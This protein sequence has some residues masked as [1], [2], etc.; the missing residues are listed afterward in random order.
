MRETETAGVARRI[1]ARTRVEN[2]LIHAGNL[3]RHGK[4]SRLGGSGWVVRRLGVDGLHGNAE[5][6]QRNAQE[7]QG[8]GPYAHHPRKKRLAEASNRHGLEDFRCGKLMN[9][10]A[11]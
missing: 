8:C 6:R 4:V 10:V 11:D 1:A 5:N 3:H 7:Q 9:R 2:G